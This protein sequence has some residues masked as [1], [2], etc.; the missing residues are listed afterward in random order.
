MGPDSIGQILS[1]PKP[2]GSEDLPVPPSSND[3]LDE[4]DEIF[5]TRLQ[6]LDQ[7]GESQ[8]RA[9]SER[10]RLQEEFAAVCGEEIRPA[11]QAFLE[12][13]RQNGGG[14][15]LEERE[16]VEGAGVA[17]RIRL[18]MSLS[19]EIIGRRCHFFVF[20]SDYSASLTFFILSYSPI[21]SCGLLF[22]ARCT[23]SA[24]PLIAKTKVP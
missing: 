14:G 18:W 13:L 10:T 9:Q 20:F 4:I 21:L 19:G 15:L 24:A 17:P 6:G 11:M 7:S 16:G 22:A 5:A 12:R 8:S 1:F 3:P 23:P 2:V